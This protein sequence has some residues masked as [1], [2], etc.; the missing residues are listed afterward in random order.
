MRRLLLII[1]LGSLN[2]IVFCQVNISDTFRIA[3]D[4]KNSDSIKID[5]INQYI[6]Q[7]ATSYPEIVLLYSDSAIK[8]SKNN[9]DSARLAISYNRK[10]VAHYFLGDYSNSLENYFIALSIKEKM[11][12]KSSIYKEYNN[13]GLV[14]R[15]LEQNTEA[16]KYFK[17]ALA[18]QAKLSNKNSEAILWN[19]I[20]ISYRGLKQYDSAKVALEKALEIN[21]AIG[22][23]QNIAHNYNNLGTIFKLQSNFAKSEDYCLKALEINRS[24]QNSYEEAQNLNNLGELY[25]F[26]KFYSK[27]I[28]CLNQANS[29][30]KKINADQLLLDNLKIK[31]DYY[32]ATNDLKN[33]TVSW[34][35]YSVVRDSIYFAN[36]A[37]QFNQL[38]IL[39]NAEKEIQRVEFLER[40][41]LLQR[42]KIRVQHFIEALGGFAIITILVLLFFVIRNLMIKKK[43][44]FTLK[45]HSEELETLNEE[46]ISANE[47]LLVQREELELTLN[48]LK[49]TQRQLI[50][51]EKMTSLGILAS[52]VAHEINN[53]LNN[54]QGGIRGLKDYFANPKEHE[55]HVD[56]YMTAIEEGLDRSISIVSGL[57]H[58]S[59]F[60]DIISE[61]ID[62]HK[63]IETCLL[64]LEHKTKD[65]ITI[66]TNF[67]TETFLLEGNDGKL[68]QAIMNILLNAVQSI[69]GI[70]QIEINSIIENSRL[71][72]YFTDTGCG[73][74]DEFQSKI[75]DPFFT[76]KE[77]GEGTGL[78]MSITY[79][80]IHEF[81]GSIEVNSTEGIGTTIIIK[82]PILV[83]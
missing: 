75:F 44:N 10:G 41:N 51:S 13:I 26:N 80:I 18:I 50:Q 25:F 66:S 71:N 12:D 76:T 36:R 83:I 46:L 11:R 77:P 64:M 9:N 28:L 82:L 34:K 4:G 81:K 6:Y 37:K 1:F 78:G 42:D 72:I 22:A 57:N 23:K 56:F 7:F 30:I 59:R 38:K 15:N 58:F 63:I 32:T 74:S 2:F 14:L 67:T 65:R 31:A 69:D 55:S 5:K 21:T 79:N 61:K 35:K 53:P 54:I 68:H 19:N 43:L 39:A 8:I 45:E 16:L 17:M 52:G 62:I 20:G 73:M 40:M 27:S 60:E 49:N 47:E 29:I 24:L 70:G 48:T 3:L 33:S